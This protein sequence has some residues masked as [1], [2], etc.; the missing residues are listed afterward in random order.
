[1]ISIHT[2]SPGWLKIRQAALVVDSG[3]IV[4]YPTEAVYGLGC[5]PGDHDAVRRI[6]SLKRRREAAGLI[7]I[8]ADAHQLDGW[9]EPDG[10][11]RKRMAGANEGVTW[12]VTAGCAAPRWITGGRETV[13]VRVTRHPL[14]ATLCRAA[15]MPL[16]STSANRR[17]HAPARDALAARRMFGP[18]LDFVLA[19]PTGG[20]ARPSEI[21]DAR[22]GAL[23]RAG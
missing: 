14:A 6:L 11:E 16:V 10:A 9:I 13:A 23:L 18:D 2:P 22:T 8:A 19:G 21:R 5:D 4:A 20:R 1:M 7:L 12:V 3:G 17:G 15:G